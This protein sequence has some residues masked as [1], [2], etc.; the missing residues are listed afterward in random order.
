MIHFF[1]LSLSPVKG[2]ELHGQHG[3]RLGLGRGIG[4]GD[5]LQVDALHR[6]GHQALEDLLDVDS[7]LRL[8][9]A[10]DGGGGGGGFQHL[11][12]RRL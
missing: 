4:G 11:H 10:D 6:S 9:D 5:G 8:A 1:S 12:A 3:V 7:P 2:V